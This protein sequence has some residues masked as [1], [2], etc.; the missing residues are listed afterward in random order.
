MAR[1]CHELKP[2]H[3]KLTSEI[4]ALI[5]SCL[6]CFWSPEQI[7]DRKRYGSAHNRTGIPNHRDISERPTEANNRTS[8]GHWETDTI[9]SNQHQ[10]ALVTLDERKTKLRLAASLPSKKAAYTTAAV[11]ALLLPISSFAKTITFD[12]G[13][14]FARH[15]DMGKGT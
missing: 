11:N 2:K 6:R 15:E 4:R 12:N 7:A 1:I 5:D 10:G 14:E 13:K 9:I 8:V 3:V